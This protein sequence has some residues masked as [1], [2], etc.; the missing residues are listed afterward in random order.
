MEMLNQ[1]DL[2]LKHCTDSKM[3]LREGG[4]SYSE[5]R[6]RVCGWKRHLCTCSTWY[7]GY[8]LGEATAASTLW[9]YLERQGQPTQSRSPILHHTAPQPRS[10]GGNTPDCC[11]TTDSMC[12][13][14]YDGDLSSVFHVKSHLEFPSLAVCVAG[15]NP[16]TFRADTY[17]AWLSASPEHKQSLTHRWPQRSPSP[18]PS[19]SQPRHNTAP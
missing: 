3:L 14:I 7:L 16:W 4:G 11:A 17:R 5:P 19:H 12:P 2:S 18:A 15:V 10:P 1:Q 13:W 6:T 9:L 8:Y